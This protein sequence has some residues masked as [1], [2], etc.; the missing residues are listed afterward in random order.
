MLGLALVR[1]Q[2]EFESAT[3]RANR[4]ICKPVTAVNPSPPD[5]AVVSRIVLKLIERRKNNV[6]LI[7]LGLEAPVRF[8][9]KVKLMLPGKGTPLLT[10]NWKG[11][12]FVPFPFAAMLA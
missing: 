1:P 4:P 12:V 11:V 3:V 6:K 8:T 5:G 2:L 10:T 9:V 7:T